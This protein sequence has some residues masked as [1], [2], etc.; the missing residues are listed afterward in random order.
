[1]A[2]AMGYI[3]SPPR[4]FS[5]MLFYAL[6]ARRFAKLL[7]FTSFIEHGCAPVIIVNQR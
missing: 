2:D 4:G 1:M 5:V 7:I 6:L 3:L